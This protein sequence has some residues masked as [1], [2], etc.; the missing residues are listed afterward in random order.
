MSGQLHLSHVGHAGVVPDCFSVKDEV[1][2][3]VDFQSSLTYRRQGN[4]HIA[5]KLAIEFGPYPRGLGGSTLRVSS[6]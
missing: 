5:A 4:C 6:T 3:Y 2:I 1:T